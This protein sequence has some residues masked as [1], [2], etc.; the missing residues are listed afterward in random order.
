MSVGTIIYLNG[1]SSAG[2]TSIALALLNRLDVPYLH[3]AIDLFEGLVSHPQMQRGIAPN[4]ITLAWGF[5]NCIAALAQAGNN[6]IVDDVLSA[7]WEAPADQRFTARDLLTQRV[8]ALAAFEVWY[9]KVYCPLAELEQREQLR[10]D[11]MRG[12]ARFHYDQVH[13]H[14]CY[15]VDVDTARASPDA[16]AQHILHMRTQRGDSSAFRVMQTQ[17]VR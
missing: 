10:G 5:T 1:T 12:L 14:S 17:L 8:T 15:D 11:R 13:Q 4:L 16:C 9:V 3:V 2:K 7:P 6:L